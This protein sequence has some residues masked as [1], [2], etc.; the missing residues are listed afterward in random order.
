MSAKKPEHPMQPVVLDEHGTA[1]FKRNAIVAYVLDRGPIT[2]NDL[3]RMDF[4]REDREQFAQLI[5]YSVSGFG[6]LSYVRN[7]TYT[8]AAKQVDALLNR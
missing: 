5:G 2:M 1:R 7:K 3:A 8:A 4:S 6:E